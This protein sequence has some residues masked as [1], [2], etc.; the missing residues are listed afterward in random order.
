MPF[1]FKIATEQQQ[2]MQPVS[3]VGDID[4]LKTCG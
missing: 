1:R 3:T 2:G 4:V